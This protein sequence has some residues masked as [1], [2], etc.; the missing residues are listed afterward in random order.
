MEK[1]TTTTPSKTS[2]IKWIILATA[3]GLCT[4]SCS[5]WGPTEKDVADQQQKLEKLSYQI[6]QYIN[7]RK[8]LVAKYNTLLAYPKTDANK[9][10]IN[11]SLIQ[12]WEKIC[13]YD[14]K[15]SDL[16][17]DKI[18]AESD[19]SNY[20]ANLKIKVSPNEPIDPNKR[21]FLLS[22]Q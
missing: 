6:S 17:K 1:L 12:I 2:W 15:L 10:E 7:S 8:D 9:H 18:D 5:C 22:I 4:I 19:L 14:E 20:I 11:K 13:E 21:D 16:A 3:L